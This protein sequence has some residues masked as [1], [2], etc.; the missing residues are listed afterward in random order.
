MKNKKDYK[1]II[2]FWAT[3]FL[4]GGA[5][6]ILATQFFLP[7]LATIPSLSKINWISN[8]KNGTTV[9]NKT[10]RI[11]I[12]QDLAYQDAIGRLSNSVVAVRAERQYRVVN[13]KQVPLAKPE[14]LTQGTG[15]ILTGDGVIATA[16]VLVP[17]T[18]TN[19]IVIKD[20][21]EIE[22][23]V[24]KRDEQSGLTL[25]KIGE[26]NLSV[27]SLG[28][29]ENIKLGEMVF[30]LGAENSALGGLNKFVNIGY[31]KTLAPEITFNFSESQ[32]A[33]GSPMANGRGEVLGL[34]LIDKD[35]KIKMVSE[36]KIRGLL[37]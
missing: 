24:L 37:K 22:A 14:I 36:E 23:Q 4:V 11:I 26:S 27:V 35:G 29:L 34:S 7:W 33:N 1:K 25:L 20:N 32:L 5:A 8:V 30:L 2:T 17:E 13:K 9:I 31:V 19:F 15:F 10:E 3:V 21:K 12:G 16:D 6:G 28:D 18:A